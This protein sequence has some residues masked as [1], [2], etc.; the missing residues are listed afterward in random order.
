MKKQLAIAHSPKVTKLG[1]GAMD[2]HFDTTDQKLS[3]E[4]VVL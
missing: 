2:L 3:G 4:P 1:S